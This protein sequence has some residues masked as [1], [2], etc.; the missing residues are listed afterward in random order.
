M[1]FTLANPVREEFRIASR[2][3]S[4]NKK[5]KEFVSPVIKIQVDP[6]LWGEA[7]RL[8]NEEPRR[9]RI[10]SSVEVIIENR[11]VR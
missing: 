1:K 4:R 8:S 11:P 2:S 7:L 5:N 9:I 3:K 6:K 10:I